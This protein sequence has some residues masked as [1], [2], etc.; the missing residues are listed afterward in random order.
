[1]TVHRLAAATLAV[2]AAIPSPARTVAR[3]SWA[4]AAPLHSRLAAHGITAGGFPAYVQRV[5][6]S[7]LRRVREGDL[8]HL[9]FYALQS[10]RFTDLPPIEPALSAK[11]LVESLAPRER[12][13]FLRTSRAPLARIPV[14]V[15]SRVGA[16]IRAVDLPSQDPR[17]AYFRALVNETFPVRS[18]RLPGLLHE[19]LRAMR[20]LYEKE[21]VAQ[22]S[23]GAADAVAGLYRARGLS[24]DT[25]VEA[26]YLVYLGLAI[27][28]SLD[29]NVRV[30]R[31]LI[32]G[33]G[34]D[35]APRTG[36]L[37]AGPPES[38]QPW[39][40]IDALIGLRLSRADDL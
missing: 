33:P 20:F 10:A 23:P 29:P 30:R 15:R 19:Y 5:H 11:G 22:R 9:I 27:L 17:L 34:L 16:L 31:V 37:E 35:L 4:D 24:T 21:F 32:V 40:V 25:E 12:D 28:R 26:G 18:A 7:N 13:T 2:A 14:P 39:A 3:I 36:L 38:Y 8:D 1:M 6:Q